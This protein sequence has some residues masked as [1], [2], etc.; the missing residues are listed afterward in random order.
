MN[1]LFWFNYIYNSEEYILQN[2]HKSQEHKL[3]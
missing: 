2:I 1:N 3:Q